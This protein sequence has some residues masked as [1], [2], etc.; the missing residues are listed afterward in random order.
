MGRRNPAAR[1][2][3][4]LHGQLALRPP[5]GQPSGPRRPDLV[6]HQRGVKFALVTVNFIVF[7]YLGSGVI[8]TFHHLYWS[9]S[10][11]PILALGSVFSAL[12]VVPLT[13]LDE[14]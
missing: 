4:H 9:G 5:G 8:G 3:S 10:P 2:R 6:H 13:M 7:L 12:E 11:M 14:S 1:R